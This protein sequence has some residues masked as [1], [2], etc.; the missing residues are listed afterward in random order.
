MGALPPSRCPVDIVTTTYRA[1]DAKGVTCFGGCATRVW[2][3]SRNGHGIG[4][5]PARR[6]WRNGVTGVQGVSVATVRLVS[7]AR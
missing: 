3:V 5:M 4:V 1:D 6:R 2:S 7:W